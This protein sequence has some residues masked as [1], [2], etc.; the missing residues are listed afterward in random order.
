M[1]IIFNDFWNKICFWIMF[2]SILNLFI[3]KTL[4]NKIKDEDIKNTII[5]IQYILANFLFILSLVPLIRSITLLIIKE[6]F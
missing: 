5:F 6:C 2:I 1:I 4:V 3:R